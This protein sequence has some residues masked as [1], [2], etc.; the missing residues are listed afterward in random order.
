MVVVACLPALMTFA[1]IAARRS[2]TSAS[3]AG[4]VTATVVCWSSYPIAHG[5]AGAL[6]A[7]WAPVVLEVT[8]IVFGGLL[9]RES[10][11]MT[12][13]LDNLADRLAQIVGTGPA[14]GLAVVHGV[15]PF[16]ESVTGFGIGVTLSIPLLIRLGFSS[17]RAAAVGLLGLCT[18]PWGSMGPGT[19]IAANLAGVGFKQLGTASAVVSLPL[20]LI[21]G[22][23]AGWISSPKHGPRSIVPGLASG[24]GL[25]VCVLVAN[26]MA[27]T[28]PA[29]ALGAALSLSFH[30]AAHSFHGRRRH[31]HER[32]GVDIRQGLVVALTPHVVLLGGILA[33]TMVISALG[34]G[35]TPWQ[36]ASSPAVWLP[37]AVIATIPF[38]DL[39]AAARS[40]GARWLSVGPATALFMLLGILMAVSGMARDLGEAVGGLGFGYT[41]VLA[42]V[43]ALGGYLTGSN[44]ATNAMLAAPQAQAITLVGL[45]LLPA[46]AVHNV[47]SSMALMTSPAKIELAAQMCP[48]PAQGRQ[49]LGPVLTAVLGSIVLLSALLTL[50]SVIE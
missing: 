40:A 18:V 22:V 31:L 48:D 14:A 50:I 47:S 45:P 26:L 20:F 33:T 39:G 36:Y 10:L 32:R 5:Q 23:V 35:R 15:T 21:T 38:K 4:V 42:S 16:A 7:E 19:L 27:G 11:V 28:A 34:L 2:A 29:G 44:S 41:P 46:M 9:L 43:G 24:T 37:A 25:W 17:R 30:I 49:V 8:L 6:I 1:M 3:L 12:G 13:R